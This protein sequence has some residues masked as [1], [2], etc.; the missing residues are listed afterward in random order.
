MSDPTKI[1]SH[2]INGEAEFFDPIEVNRRIRH[3]LQGDDINKII[4]QAN[5]GR[6]DDQ[7]QV[8][9][10]PEV[11]P[12]LAFESRYRFLDAIRFGFKLQPFNPKTGEGP[13]E[14]DCDDLW[15]AYIDWSQKKSQSTVS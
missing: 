11:P 12:A 6:L 3:N 4:D 8:I 14:D 7:G 5:V 13:T 2:Q 10:N 15:Q 9:F 1:F